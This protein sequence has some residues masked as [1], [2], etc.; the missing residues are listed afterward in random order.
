LIGSD[1]CD[2]FQTSVVSLNVISLASVDIILGLPWLKANNA[3]VGGPRGQLLFSSSLLR[4]GV[5]SHLQVS[6]AESSPTNNP[7]LLNQD[8]ILS[9]PSA[10]RCYSDVFTVASLQS[11]PPVRPQFDFRIQ[12]K[13][14][15]TPPFGGL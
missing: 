12:L 13:E 14:G 11:L 7:S 10:L 3:W 5:S 15:S 9:L 6:S 1:S 4:S 8:E 2:S